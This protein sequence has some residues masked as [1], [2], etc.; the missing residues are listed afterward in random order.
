[1]VSP[2]GNTSWVADAA[3]G[4]VSSTAARS[5]VAPL[6]VIKVRFQLQGAAAAA[7]RAAPQYR[8]VLHALRTVVADEGALALWKGNLAAMCMVGV[9]GAAQFAV[10]H[11][12]DG[13]AT[14]R[15][16]AA[17]AAATLASYPLDL[18]RTRM[19]A[20]QS[21]RLYA[22]LG[23]ALRS[24]VRADGLVGLYAGVGPT[25]VGIVP[26]VGIQFGTFEALR[27]LLPAARRDNAAWVAACGGA[28]GLVS[29]TATMPFDVVKKRQQVRSFSWEL[30][31]LRAPG[32][33]VP[34][35]RAALDTARHIVRTEGL[36]GL[37]RGLSP[38]LLKAGPA[39]SLTLTLFE[40]LRSRLGM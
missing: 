24:V 36:V 32:L 10:Y 4:T 34:R 9:F 8:G 19:A 38:A 6:D 20:Q 23:H 21:R 40:A 28:A 16:A 22:G 35:Q 7:E 37:Y 14:V 2:S 27:A 12:V 1:M 13:P 30:T 18:L 15:G 5:V 3:V 17:G 39:S 25:L 29:K 33:A 11:A 26:N 31:R